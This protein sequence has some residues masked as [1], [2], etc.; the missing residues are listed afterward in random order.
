M[1][2]DRNL[3][4]HTHNEESANGLYARLPL[5]LAAPPPPMAAMES[6]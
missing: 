6:G 2:Q 5:Y 3:S 1:V 4:V